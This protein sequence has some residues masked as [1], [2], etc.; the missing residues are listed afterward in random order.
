[1]STDPG[2]GGR[3]SNPSLH[4]AGTARARIAVLGRLQVVRDGAELAEFDD[5]KRRQAPV[6]RA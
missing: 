6:Q 4:C 5:L 2:Y 3:A 1:V